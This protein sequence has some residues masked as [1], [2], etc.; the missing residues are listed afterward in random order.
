MDF[1]P[2]VLA[3]GCCAWALPAT[4][5]PFLVVAVVAFAILGPVSGDVGE[6]KPLWRRGSLFHA[7]VAVFETMI[8]LAALS[9]R[10]SPIERDF[11]A[12]SLFTLACRFRMSGRDAR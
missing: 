10:L 2:L 3:L 11:V 8:T 1:R 9:M 4:I 5:S 7:P 12:A 6:R